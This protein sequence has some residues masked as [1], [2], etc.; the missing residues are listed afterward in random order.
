MRISVRFFASFREL[1]GLSQVELEVP[2]GSTTDNLRQLL[3][4]RFPSFQRGPM[5]M[6]VNAEFADPEQVL[7]NGDEVALFPP[8]SGG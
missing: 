5:L 6:A 4:E 2:Y 3:L 1:A 7:Q 8:L